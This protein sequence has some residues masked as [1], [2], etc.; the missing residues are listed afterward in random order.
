M[1]SYLG[2]VQKLI[3]RE[4]YGRGIKYYLEGRVTK[5]DDLALDFWRSY[6]V[7]ENHEDVNIKIPLLHLA[8]SQSRYPTA[9]LALSQVVSCTC[10]YF[11]E[12]GVCKHIVAVCASI[13]Q[14]F[15]LNKK[16]IVQN[17]D[18]GKKV[19]SL[20]ETIFEAETDKKSRRWQSQI[21]S[22]IYSSSSGDPHW[23]DEAISEVSNNQDQYQ[24]FLTGFR[25]IILEA[26][27]T[28]EAE[29]RIINLI[30]QS[31]YFGGRFWWRFWQEFLDRLEDSNK[32][33]LWTSIWKMY[34][35]GAFKD[36]QEEFLMELRRLEDSTKQDILEAL[37]K[38]FQGQNKVWVTFA[39]ESHY[40][41]WLMANLDIFDPLNLLKLYFILPEDQDDI[42][43]RVY[44]QVKVWSDFLQ[45][46]NYAELVATMKKWENSVG[47]T[48]YYEMAL[49]Y[50]KDNHSKKKKLMNELEK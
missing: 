23:F 43:R 22:Y 47:R 50:V 44:N 48:D 26:L 34:I 12:Y 20:L 18:T 11:Q 30:K 45:S 24:E 1:F 35:V 27:K 6:T 42:E 9:D 25:G 29:L 8:L 13:E 5:F 33:K 7:T 28:W 40:K 41:L 39:I 21:E 46:G 31:L 15:G 10:N 2:A 4:I 14:E 32:L 17:S 19:D 49:K 37:K 3:G 36:F 38:E 16:L